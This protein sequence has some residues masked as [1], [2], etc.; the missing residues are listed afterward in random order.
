MSNLYQVLPDYLIPN[1][2]RSGREGFPV[3][4]PIWS[5][6]EC[7]LPMDMLVKLEDDTIIPSPYNPA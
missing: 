7:F 6:G 1:F 3:Y 5:L 4:H 2:Y